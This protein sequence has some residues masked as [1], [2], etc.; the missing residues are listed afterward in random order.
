MRCRVISS[1]VSWACAFL[2]PEK[3]ISESVKRASILFI[4]RL[5][6]GEL[7]AFAT[8]WTYVGLFPF[9]RGCC[10]PKRNQQ[11]PDFFGRKSTFLYISQ[12]K[13]ITTRLYLWLSPAK[14]Q[15]LW[16]HDSKAPMYKI[17]A[18]VPADINGDFNIKIPY[19]F[20]WMLFK[21]FFITW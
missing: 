20:L 2:G 9:I 19:K 1:L 12:H 16:R 18:A 6:G 21:W 3:T 5:A 11:Q 8:P 14:D 10:F 4:K 17:G 7:N 15:W 13:K